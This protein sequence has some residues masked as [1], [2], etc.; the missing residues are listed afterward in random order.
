MSKNIPASVRQRLRDL[1]GRRNED[2]GFVLTKYGM[3]RVCFGL[4]ARNTESPSC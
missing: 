3:E 4:A 2:F 1:A